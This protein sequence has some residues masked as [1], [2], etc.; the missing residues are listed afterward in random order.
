MKQNGAV[1]AYQIIQIHPHPGRIQLMP[2]KKTHKG[3]EIH[4]HCCHMACSQPVLTR[5]SQKGVQQRAKRRNQMK[6]PIPMY[7]IMTQK[8][9]SLIH[10]RCQTPLQT[11]RSKS[12]I[13][14]NTQSQFHT[15]HCLGRSKGCQFPK[16]PDCVQ[17]V[18]AF[19]TK[20][21]EERQ[22]DWKFKLL[23]TSGY[24]KHKEKLGL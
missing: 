14:T 18:A 12:H 15:L 17:D 20:W 10:T 3:K 6:K 4:R 9:C 24:H 11:E 5:H 13:Q 23:I 22:L 7:H 21:F 16:E 8:G 1:A 19:T 2:A